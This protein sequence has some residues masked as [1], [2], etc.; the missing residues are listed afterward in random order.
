MSQLPPDH[1]RG[2]KIDEDSAPYWRG[3][4]AHKIVAQT[5]LSCGE[6]RVPPIPSCPRCAGPSFEWTDVDPFGVVYSWVVIRRPMAGLVESDVPRVIATV[7]LAGGSRVV[8]RIVGPSTP[9]FGCRV[10][11]RFIEHAGWT[12]LAFAEAEGGGQ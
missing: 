3:L 12:E 9:D 10:S 1:L 4:A 8:A 6:E 7:E 11:A 2:P 5:C